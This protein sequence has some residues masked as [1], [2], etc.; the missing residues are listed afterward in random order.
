MHQQIRYSGLVSGET[1]AS[2]GVAVMSWI[3]SE[4]RK[5]RGD[6]K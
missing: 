4:S 6:T 1:C 2:K 5:R 3:K